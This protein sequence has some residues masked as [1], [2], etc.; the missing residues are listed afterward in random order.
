MEG[1]KVYEEV[2]SR[3]TREAVQVT[4]ENMEAVAEWCEGTIMKS[5]YTDEPFIA[6]AKANIAKPGDWVVKHGSTFHT[7]SS[8]F[9]RF[10]REAP[11]VKTSYFTFGQQHLH[12]Y[13]DRT[14]DRNTVVKITA[15]RPRE[16]MKQLFGMEWSMEYDEAPDPEVFPGGVIEID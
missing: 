12:K 16:V 8:D 15:R 7:W 9:E 1:V 10:Y 6:V 11:E 3:S 13:G 14:V 2:P 5:R 4:A